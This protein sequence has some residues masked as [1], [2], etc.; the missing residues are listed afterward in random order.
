MAPNISKNAKTNRTATTKSVIVYNGKEVEIVP[1]FF[2]GIT[3]KIG[4]HKRNRQNLVSSDDNDSVKEFRNYTA[5]QDKTSKE[6]LLDKK[7][8]PLEWNKVVIENKKIV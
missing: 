8:Q 1:A 5:V 4:C 7:G 2:I 3:K 6:L